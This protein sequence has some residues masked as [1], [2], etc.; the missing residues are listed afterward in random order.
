MCSQFADHVI[1]DWAE[2]DLGE[3]VIQIDDR[4]E[5]LF[6]LAERKSVT[7]EVLL[8]I[9]QIIGRVSQGIERQLRESNA[10]SS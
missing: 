10:L 7:S 9:R 8:T 2:V 1:S 5:E 3:S 6:T 4:Y